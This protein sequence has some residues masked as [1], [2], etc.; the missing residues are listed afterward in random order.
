MC[1]HY[2]DDEEEKLERL[3]AI[4]PGLALPAALPKL[5]VQLYPKY[6]ARV[7]VQEGAARSLVALRWGVWPFFA[8]EK[9]QYL[10]NA[11]A[12]GLLVKPVWK[13][14][15]AKRRCLI[16]ATGYYEPG[17]G[18]PGAKGEILFTVRERPRFFIAGLWDL[19]PDA[20]G[21]RAFTMVTTE[22]NETAARFHDRMP[23]VLADAEATAWLGDEPIPDD[24]LRALCRGLPAEAL[25]HETLPPKLKITKKTSAKPADDGQTTLL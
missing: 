19:D 11:R 17:L 15:A 16:P 24:C 14:S 1:N 2:R 13:Q 5:P 25:L 8:R 23:V 18:P 20:S 3:R 22:P 10:T 6:P 7:I 4:L 12:D 9:A 21:T